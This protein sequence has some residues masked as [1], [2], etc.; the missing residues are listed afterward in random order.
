MQSCL[1]DA[2]GDA[3]IRKL[4]STAKCWPTGHVRFRWLLRGTS[5]EEGPAMDSNTST[6]DVQRRKSV[7]QLLNPIERLHRAQSHKRESLVQQMPPPSAVPASQS[8]PSQIKRW[9][10]LRQRSPPPGGICA[11]QTASSPT[12][13]R[14]SLKERAC[15]LLQFKRLSLGS[16][17]HKSPT[18]SPRTSSCYSRSIDTDTT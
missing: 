4:T 2:N 3:F 13:R 12:Q 8:A 14:E 15:S 17:S 16:N 1:E 7:M 10:S 6:S 5:A 11:S 9:T 18:S